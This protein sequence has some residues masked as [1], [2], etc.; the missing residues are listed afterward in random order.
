MTLEERPG[1]LTED[2]EAGAAYVSLHGRI[3]PRAR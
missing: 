1:T 2:P 3:P